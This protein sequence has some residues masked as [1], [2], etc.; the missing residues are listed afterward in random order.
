VPTET[1][2]TNE[3]T[4]P[5]GGLEIVRSRDEELRKL[6]LRHLERVRKFKLYLAVYLLSLLVLTPV[7]IITQYETQ[8]GWLRHLSSRSRYAGDWDPWIIWVA[9]GGAVF[10]AIAG[11][12][13]YLDRPTT[14]EEID[15]EVERLN[16]R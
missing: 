1:T 4:R 13:A 5:E 16:T 6:A 11:F 8:D 12:R 14:E 9:L 2:T 10:V 7:W 15:R 3:R